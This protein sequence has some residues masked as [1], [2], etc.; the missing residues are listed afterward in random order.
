MRIRI[1]RPN[2]YGSSGYGTLI[3]KG[4]LNFLPAFWILMY[5]VFFGIRRCGSG[6]CTA[7]FVVTKNLSNRL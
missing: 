6:S 1:G 2:N 7:I 3:V 5:Q 4:I